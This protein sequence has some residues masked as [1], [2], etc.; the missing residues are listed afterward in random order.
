MTANLSDI[1]QGASD[2][3]LLAEAR[4]AGTISEDST[5]AAAARALLDRKARAL[6]VTGADGGEVGVVTATDL[7]RHL[8]ESEPQFGRTLKTLP[9]APVVTEALRELNAAGL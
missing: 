7:L 5:I 8:A 4:R 3:E 6:I 1:H 2:A 9:Y